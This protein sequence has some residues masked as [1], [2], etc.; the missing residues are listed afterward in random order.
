MSET[1][2]TSTILRIEDLHIDYRN[3]RR[4]GVAVDE[5]SFEIGAGESV[6]LVGESGCGKST[7]ALSIMKLLPPETKIS[8]TIEFDGKNLVTAGQTD[9]EVIRGAKIGMVFQ[10]PMTALNPVHRIGKQIAEVLLRHQNISRSD[11]RSRALDL[12]RQVKLPDAE[13]KID[14]YPHELSGGQRQRVVIAMAIALKP[15]LLIADE[16]TTALDAS[17]RGQIMELIDDLR[18]EMNMAVLLISHDLP[19]V[20]QWTDRVVVMHHGRIMERIRSAALYEHARHPYTRG[21][22]GAS[23]RPGEQRHYSTARL[24]E[25]SSSMTPDGDFAFSLK[26]PPVVPTETRASDE[27]LAIS[28]LTVRYGKR[29]A[30]DAV[31]LTINR[32]STVGLVGESGCGKSTLS[33]AIMGLVAPDNGVI[34][35]G[36]DRISGLSASQMRPHR[37]RLQMVFQDPF[38]SLNARHSVNTILDGILKANG[39]QSSADRRKRILKSLDEVSLPSSAASRLP[40]EFSGGQ[41]QRIASA[42]ALILRPELVILDEP[43]S[44]LDVSIQAQILNLLADLKSELG[45]TYLF[46]SHDMSV[47][48]FIS[49]RIVVMRDGAITEQ[50]DVGK[51]DQTGGLDAS[52]IDDLAYG[53]D[54]KRQR[55]S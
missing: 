6:A 39:V 12:L 34:S 27:V 10:E 9:I 31:T 41:R 45:L 32:G 3:T 18:R 37:K 40:H 50:G 42:R 26:E 23:G 52:A 7:T 28:D 20:S 33:R 24:T 29:N 46:I 51:V 15:K 21:L 5:I 43:T 25:V 22:I 17:L 53:H 30:V 14:S 16:P 55:V 48:R 1:I 2:M 54:R 4:T 44:A 38:A 19:L 11:A 47:V 49:D 35:L 36:G 13:R 8:G